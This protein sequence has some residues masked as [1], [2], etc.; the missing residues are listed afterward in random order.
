MFTKGEPYFK[1]E[2]PINPNYNEMFVCWRC[3]K[4]VEV[5]WAEPLERVFCS[6]CFEAYRTEHDN[7][8][9]EYSK[10]K[11]KVMYENALRI[12]EKSKKIFM[13]E[14]LEAS[15]IVYEMAISESEKFMS[16]SEI[17]VAILLQEY[18]F[19][20]YANYSILSYRVDFY[21]PELKVCVEVDGA[22]HQHKLEYDSNRDIEIRN[23]LGYEWEIVRIPVKY[24][25]ENPSKIIDGIEALAEEKRRLRKKHQGYMPYG[26]SQR[27]NKHYDRIFKSIKR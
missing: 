26:F 14:Y 17:I 10:L 1:P 27:E 18:G 5:T 25:E 20:Y 6:D 12:M 24:I 7:L 4:E 16:S 11:I 15:K 23:A 22:L 21:V 2:T 19:E 13:H 3:G 8:V 9:S